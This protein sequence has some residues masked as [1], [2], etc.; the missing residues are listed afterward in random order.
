MFIFANFIS[1]FAEILNLVLQLAIWL[2]IARALTSWVN[3]DPYN[4]IVFFL[5]K[6]T[7]PV[8]LP[9][10]RKLPLSAID[11]SPIIVIFVIVFAQIFLVQS[12]K[13]LALYLRHL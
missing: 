1:A 5:Y 7:E 9:V 13:D 2:I 6:T 8:L 10:R 3:A 12:L 11:L 4:P